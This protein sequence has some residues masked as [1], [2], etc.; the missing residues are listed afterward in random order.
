MEFVPWTPP[1][2]SVLALQQLGRRL[3]Q[4]R[5]ELTR[6]EAR[7]HAIAYTPDQNGLI[8]ADLEASIRH[9]KKR[10]EAL[11][12]AAVAV[13]EKDPALA[14]QLRRVCSVPGIGKTSALRL[15]GELLVL[16]KDLKAP[17]WVAHAGLDPRP[18][19][20]GKKMPRAISAAPAT[21]TC[22]WL[23]SCLRW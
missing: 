8:A 9:L 15:L 10:I 17:Q 2:D 1:A 20:A 4:L 3:L 7:L 23:C 6:E 14:L 5:G 21:A 16:P 12:L 22:V 13:A 18:A 19:R 11:H